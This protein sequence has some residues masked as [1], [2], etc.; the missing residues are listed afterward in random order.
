M[1]TVRLLTMA[2]DRAPDDPADPMRER[3]LDAALEL[4]AAAGTRHLTMDD[5]AARARVGRM[6]VYRRFGTRQDLLDALTVREGRRCLA[7]IAGSFAPADPLD[8]RVADVFVATLR[9][10]REHPLLARLA[11]IEPEALLQELTRNDS[12]VFA[13]VCAFLVAQVRA[14]QSTGELAGHDPELLAELALRL[15]ASFVLLPD[16]AFTHGDEQRTRETMR[17]LL[18]PFVR[19]G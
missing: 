13:L 12:E 18:E 8:A 7:E 1:S 11:R 5:V 14:A 17:A 19:P 6:T 16:S 15:G 10:I 2:L 3:I 9:V 4:V